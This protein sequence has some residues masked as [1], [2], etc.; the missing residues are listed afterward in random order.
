MIELIQSGREVRPKL[1][2]RILDVE[3]W[4]LGFEPGERGVQR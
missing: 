4:M 2:R 1:S 3:G